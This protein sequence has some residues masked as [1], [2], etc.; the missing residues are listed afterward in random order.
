MGND[1]LLTAVVRNSVRW[2]DAVCRCHG[3]LGSLGDGHWA[4][5]G[6]V[7]PFHPDLVTLRAGISAADVA[8]A[9]AG[10]ERP[11]ASRPLSVKDSFATLDLTPYGF[12]VL[13]EA[14]WIVRMPDA[15]SPS[16]SGCAE[17]WS[18]VAD[19][20]ALRA[21]QAAWRGDDPEGAEDVFLPALLDDPRV[22]VLQARAVAA[23][24]IAFV[25]DGVVGLSNVFAA[26]GPSVDTWSSCIDV[27]TRRFPDTPVVGYE[28]GRELAC[29]LGAGFAAVGPLRV[30]SRP[31]P[32][33][34]PRGRA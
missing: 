4:C 31:A 24:A 33:S 19:A 23:G 16:A 27:V 7:P 12:D 15:R 29:A 18:A 25:S 10:L 8:P 21:W 17:E 3:C 14:T 20:S 28:R 32:A 1:E 2:C 13:F 5:R 11:G 34:V 9:I 30:W 22:T 26:C 6:P